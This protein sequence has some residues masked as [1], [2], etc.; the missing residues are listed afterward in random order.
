MA[1]STSADFD[2]ASRKK[3]ATIPWIVEIARDYR[4]VD[5]D[6]STSNDHLYPQESMF[7]E[8]LAAT[9]NLTTTRERQ[10]Y[11]CFS[12]TLLPQLGLGSGS[13]PAAGPPNSNLAFPP[14][15]EASIMSMLVYESLF[16]AL[17]ED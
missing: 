4:S 16:R 10:V 5:H 17:K 14:N 1:C 7:S 9:P 6:I 2:F 13:S 11:R 3:H 12:V 8:I 15:I